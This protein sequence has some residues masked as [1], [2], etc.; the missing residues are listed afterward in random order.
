MKKIN[1]KKIDLG[2]II[3]FTTIL[4]RKFFEIPDF[5]YGLGIGI[6]ATLI[7]IWVYEF[8]HMKKSIF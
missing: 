3:I 2:L 8:R 1:T 7:V 6:S 4:L 5:I